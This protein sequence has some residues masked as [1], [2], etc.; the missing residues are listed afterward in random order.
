ML[1]G[2]KGTFTDNIDML[3]FFSSW[4]GSFMDREW[5]ILCLISLQEISVVLFWKP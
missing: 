1:S 3:T 4:Y 2:T 5:L